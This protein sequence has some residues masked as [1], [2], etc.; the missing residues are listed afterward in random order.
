MKMKNDKDEIKN[1]RRITKSPI[2]KIHNDTLHSPSTTKNFNIKETK[3]VS[4]SLS[5]KIMRKSSN[6]NKLIDDDRT[7]CAK[8][9][10][11][12]NSNSSNNEELLIDTDPINYE[13]LNDISFID[14]VELLLEQDSEY[15]SDDNFEFCGSSSKLFNDSVDNVASLQASASF[16]ADMKTQS[17]DSNVFEVEDGKLIIMK[18]NIIYLHGVTKLTVVK[19]H[20]E[21]LGYGLEENKPYDVYSPRGSSFLYIKKLPHESRLNITTVLKLLNTKL[22]LVKDFLKQVNEDDAL[23][24][25]Q[26]VNNR[27]I[28][29]LEKYVPH[30]LFPKNDLKFKLVDNLKDVNVINISPAWNDLI[31]YVKTDSRILISGGKS[32]GKST[33]LRYMINKLLRRYKKILVVDLDPGQ[34]EFTVPGCVSSTFVTTPLLG[35]NYTHLCK[36][37]RY[38][39]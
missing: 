33:L 3:D 28:S 1:N 5:E 21:I 29:T 37:D 22:Q 32:V 25:C 16:N 6:K 8:R 14:T 7:S 18:Q 23:I 9:S 10:K 38:T 4:P 36:P 15:E 13:S 17:N 19:G 2:A 30:Q 35:P 31:Q 24:F 12:R 11:R 34:A 27:L 39:S 26:L 20:V